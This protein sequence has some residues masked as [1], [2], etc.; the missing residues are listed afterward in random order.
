[1]KTITRRQ[2]LKKSSSALAAA[3]LGGSA[4]FLKGCSTKKDF[5]LIIKG[6][7]VFDGLGQEGIQADIGIKEN[8]I[9][10]IGDI[11]AGKGKAVIEA[12]GLAAQTVNVASGE[13]YKVRLEGERLLKV[14]QAEAK[15]IEAEGLRKAE[16][17]EKLAEA[18]EKGGMGL[19][20]EALAEKYV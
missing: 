2:F 4:L 13:A 14:A 9:H 12:E 15:A 1:M 16:G 18:Y 20:R 7:T 11:P 10:K 6:G 17:I 5:D 8:L 19:I 3:G